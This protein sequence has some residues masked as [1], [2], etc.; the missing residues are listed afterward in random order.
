MIGVDNDVGLDSI[1]CVLLWNFYIGFLG[2]T[3]VRWAFGSVL[4]ALSCVLL[5]WLLV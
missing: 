2:L 5:R 1:G 4:R 3:F